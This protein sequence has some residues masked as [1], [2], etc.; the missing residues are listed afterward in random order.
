MPSGLDLDRLEHVRRNGGK[1]LARC[2]ACAEQGMDENGTNLF[3]AKD[4]RFG[5]VLHPGQDGHAHRRRIFAL[6]GHQGGGRKTTDRQR[7]Y[8]IR[9]IPAFRGGGDVCCGR[10]GHPFPTYANSQEDSGIEERAMH[11]T[12][13]VVGPGEVSAPSV[14]PADCSGPTSEIPSAPSVES[15]FLP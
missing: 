10:G 13:E 1:T 7:G 9:I 12:Q 14:S 11:V 6:A 8:Q 15:A 3:I 4:G 2:P 5:C